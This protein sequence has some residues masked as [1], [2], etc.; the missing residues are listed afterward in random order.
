MI[1]MNKADYERILEHAKSVVP[2][3]ERPEPMPVPWLT[4]LTSI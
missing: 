2:E 4:Y 1:S 3:E